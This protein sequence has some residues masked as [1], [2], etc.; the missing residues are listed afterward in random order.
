MWNPLKAVGNAIGRV[1]GRGE[2]TV[3]P[4]ERVHEEPTVT[5]PIP[6]ELQETR[7]KGFFGRLWGRITG[8]E[9]EAPTEQREEPVEEAGPVIP[10]P[11]LEKQSEPEPELPMFRGDSSSDFTER[12]EVAFGE[13][14]D[15]I[16]ALEE[17]VD[18]FIMD[19]G[20]LDGLSVDAR[21]WLESP[22]ISSIFT[23]YWQSGGF[24][25]E[26]VMNG[27]TTISEIKIS[28]REDGTIE[29]EFDY[30]ADVDGYEVAG[31]AGI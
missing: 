16:R 28:E 23:E 26:Q 15:I 25:G 12:D 31:H 7:E 20:G 21:E 8:A 27:M 1:F 13:D 14:N 29:I 5:T 11:E 17:K 9:R 10:Q 6:P 24:S 22:T 19:R 2:E 4:V 30:E 18:D 3:T